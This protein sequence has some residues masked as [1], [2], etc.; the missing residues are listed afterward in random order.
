MESTDQLE[1]ERERG[2]HSRFEIREAHVQPTELNFY[3]HR[4]VIESNSIGGNT[5][6][7]KQAYRL[8]QHV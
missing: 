3:S 6:R 4:Q 1:R 5:S 8:E 7:S 2:I